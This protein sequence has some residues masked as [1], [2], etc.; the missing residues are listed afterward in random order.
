MVHGDVRRGLPRLSDADRHG[1]GSSPER[2]D[3]APGG[4]DTIDIDAAPIPDLFAAFCDRFPLTAD[5]LNDVAAAI[6]RDIYE[7]PGC[8]PFARRQPGSSRSSNRWRLD[9][10]HTDV[11][12]TLRTPDHGL[13]ERHR[14]C[15]VVVGR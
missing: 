3:P 13:I 6:D 5:Q 14:V 4:V 2:P 10:F 8:Q 7:H 12:A 9:R 15:V 1:N 11:G